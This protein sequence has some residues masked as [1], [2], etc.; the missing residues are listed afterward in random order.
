MTTRRRLQDVA[1]AVALA[2][3]LAVAWSLTADG[4]GGWWVAGPRALVAIGA[5]AAL[6]RWWAP[7]LALA[8]PLSL[9]GTRAGDEQTASLIGAAVVVAFLIALG[10]L[11]RSVGERALT[12]LRR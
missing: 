6:P 7:V 10:A 2:V 12:L 8:V 9:T 1:L 4:A 5:G 3:L 11:A